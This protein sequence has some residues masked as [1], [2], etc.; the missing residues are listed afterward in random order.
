MEAWASVRALRYL[1][2][3]RVNTEDVGGEQ[4]SVSEV[5]ILQT[6]EHEGWFGGENARGNGAAWRSS[7]GAVLGRALL[8]GHPREQRREV[9]GREKLVL[10]QGFDHGDGA[11]DLGPVRVHDRV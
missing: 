9:S 10:V 6:R 3:Q 11:R 4:R 8:R 7:A 1:L 5:D 2:S